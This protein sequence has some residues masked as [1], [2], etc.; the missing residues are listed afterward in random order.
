MKECDFW[1]RIKTKQNSNEYWGEVV[2]D[3]PHIGEIDPCEGDRNARK[4]WSKR[5]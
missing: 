5:S 3:E 1:K 2:G 4:G